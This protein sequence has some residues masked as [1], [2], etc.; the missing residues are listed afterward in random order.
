MNKIYEQYR[1][2]ITNRERFVR[3]AE[4]RVN[5]IMDALEKLGDCSNQKNLDYSNPD[6]KKIFEKIQKKVKETRLKFQ[7]SSE[8][9]RRQYE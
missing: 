4:R 1:K 9:K 6:I 2:E 8:K 3:M 5:R 7:G